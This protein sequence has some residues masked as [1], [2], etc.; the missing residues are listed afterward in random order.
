MNTPRNLHIVDDLHSP[1]SPISRYTPIHANNG[2]YSMKE[3]MI[4]PTV[5]AGFEFIADNKN[6]AKKHHAFL[7]AVNSDVSMQGIMDEKNASLAERAALEDQNTRA[8]KVALPLALQNPERDIYV[9]FYDE[10]TPEELYR[11]LRHD[12][13]C[14]LMTLHKWGYGT[15]PDAPKIIGS[16]H[17]DFTIGYPLP[18]DIKP[19]CYDITPK[20]SNT[21]VSV[22]NL[23]KTGPYLSTEGNL[24]FPVKHPSLDRFTQKGVDEARALSALAPPAPQ[25]DQP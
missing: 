15:T 21:H 3:E 12:L 6:L 7:I 18:N 14:D 22:F 8:M 20:D 19:I 13:G 5:L 24:L 4:V 9:V 10:S 2:I 11:T 23:T 17:F 16:D 25:P 1:L